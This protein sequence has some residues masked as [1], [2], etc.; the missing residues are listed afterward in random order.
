MLKYFIGTMLPPLL[1]ITRKQLSVL[2]EY[3]P[4]FIDKEENT[5]AD[6]DD[7]RMAA[8]EVWLEATSIEY[9]YK[10]IQPKNKGKKDSFGMQL[11]MNWLAPYDPNT[12]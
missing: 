11:L 4:T 5:T 9:A 3:A 12:L 1:R 6:A 10:P 7:V 8:T 2:E